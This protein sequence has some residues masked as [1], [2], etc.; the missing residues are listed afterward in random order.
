MSYLPLN[1]IF[2]IVLSSFCFDFEIF[3]FSIPSDHNYLPTNLT[4]DKQSRIL[5]EQVK[6]LFTVLIFFNTIMISKYSFA[7]GWNFK[8]MPILA[9]LA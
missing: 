8:D 6:L 1:N 3:T 5:V 7:N 9:Y 2:Q 4:L